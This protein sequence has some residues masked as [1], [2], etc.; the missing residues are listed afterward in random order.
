MSRPALVGWL[1][2]F[3][4][5]AGDMLL[6]AL[7]DAGAPQEAVEEVLRALPLG[8]WRLEVQRVSRGGLEAT[9][10]QVLVPDPP[11]QVRRAGELR[12]LLSAAA[13]PAR[14]AERAGA[15]LWALAEAEGRLHGCAPADV[16]LHEL[17]G[18]DTLVDLVGSA[19]ALELLGVGRLVASPVALG[20][21]ILSSRH[22]PLPNPAPATLA[23][24]SGRPVV[25]RD[26]PRELTTPTGAAMVAAWVEAHGPLPPLRLRATGYG[27]GQAEE[28]APNCLQ[29]VLGEP[30]GEPAGEP[31]GQPEELWLLET[32][33]D[34]VTGEL[35]GWLLATLLR[36]GALDCWSTPVVGKKGRPA[37]VLSCLC[38]QE[39]LPG[40]QALVLQQTGSLGARAW[41]VQRT[42]LPRREEVVEVRGRP[43]RVKVGPHR[44]KAEHADVA[45]LAEELGAPLAQVAAWAEAAWWERQPPPGSPTSAPPEEPAGSPGG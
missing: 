24:L 29:V 40:L 10:L 7:L 15:A 28:P 18:Q 3:S 34:D 16:H 25:G 20:V 44:V 17:G 35:L 11:D 19:A 41:P 8:G 12:D 30:L 45:A 31:A 37:Q 5:I 2:C 42:A 38:P 32:T 33:L 13:L 21:G 6:A 39:Q 22:G 9:A 26:T 43:V 1:H 23:L 27:A 14:V 36:A 4:G